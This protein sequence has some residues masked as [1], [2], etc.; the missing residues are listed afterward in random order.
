MKRTAC[1]T[2]GALL[3]CLFFTGCGKKARITTLESLSYSFTD[4]MSRYGTGRLE[5]VWKNGTYTATV[6]PVNEPDESAKT[7]RLAPE[8]VLAIEELFKQY[9]VGSWNGFDKNN[10]GV[11]DGR[12]FS[13]SV[14]M[15]EGQE[16]YARGYMKWPKNYSEVAGALKALMQELAGN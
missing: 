12:S 6:K 15:A 3:M 9:D 7:V 10:K 8:K 4:N 2:L 11:L 5:I 16:I 13:L 1:L 14:K